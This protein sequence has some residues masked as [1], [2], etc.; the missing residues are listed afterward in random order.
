MIDVSA[1]EGVI[2]TVCVVGTFGEL[3]RRNLKK[4]HQE[5]TT[6]AINAADAARDLADARRRIKELEGRRNPQHRWPPPPSDE[7]DD[8]DE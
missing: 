6:K 1:V 7:T 3:V 8:D 4:S 2:V 5:E